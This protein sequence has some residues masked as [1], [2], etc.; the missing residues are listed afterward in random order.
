MQNN[1]YINLIYMIM[2]QLKK[3]INFKYSKENK[4]FNKK[5][6]KNIQI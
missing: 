1:N 6:I 3:Y 5:L 4:I 2:T